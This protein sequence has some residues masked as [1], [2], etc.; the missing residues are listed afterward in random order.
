MTL[1]HAQYP[2]AALALHFAREI[3]I[4]NDDY[5]ACIAPIDPSQNTEQGYVEGAES[6]MPL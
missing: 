6:D 1:T 2:P 5:V 4:V 3:E